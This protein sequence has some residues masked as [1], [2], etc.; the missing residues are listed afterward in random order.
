MLFTFVFQVF[1]YRPRAKQHT[2]IKDYTAID[3]L[4]YISVAGTCRLHN[5]STDQYYHEVYALELGRLQW[6]TTTCLRLV[7]GTGIRFKNRNL[8]T[9]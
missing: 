2:I 8:S 9:R 7:L 5:E 3:S 1:V 6:R 4:Q